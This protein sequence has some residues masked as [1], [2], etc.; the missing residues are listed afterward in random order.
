LDIVTYSI[1]GA[2]SYLIAWVVPGLFIKNPL[3]RVPCQVI[4]VVAAAFFLPMPKDSKTAYFAGQYAFVGGVV[5][6]GLWSV[7]QKLRKR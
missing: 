6:V 3:V 2:V 1:V 5:L 7:I 4:A